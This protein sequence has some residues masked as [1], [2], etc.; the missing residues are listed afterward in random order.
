MFELWKIVF[1][2]MFYN[3]TNYIQTAFSFFILVKALLHSRWLI[4][5]GYGYINDNEPIG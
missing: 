5:G 3:K 1:G 2:L 4:A